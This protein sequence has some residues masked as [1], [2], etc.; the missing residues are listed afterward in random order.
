MWSVVIWWISLWGSSPRLLVLFA[1]FF[2]GRYRK[3]W[4]VFF[5]TLSLQEL[6][7]IFS[8]RRLDSRLLNI[9]FLVI[10]LGISSSICLLKRCVFLWMSGVCAVL[11]VLGREQNNRFRGLWGDIL[12]FGLVRYHVFLW[13]VVLKTFCMLCSFVFIKVKVVSIQ[14]RKE[15]VGQ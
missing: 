4:I 3:T 8:F 12:R 1:A 10:W 14:K 2:V 15:N 13:V 9:G 11:W 7:E 6:C 5:D